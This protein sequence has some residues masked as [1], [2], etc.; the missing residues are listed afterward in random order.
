MKQGCTLPGMSEI[1]PFTLAIAEEQIADL[2]RRL[3]NTRWP[4]R[5]T[6][7]DW[8]QGAPLAEVQALCEHW[9]RNYD[10]RATESRLNS[11]GQYV[12][13]IDG[14]DIHFL[15]IRSGHDGALPLLLTHGWPGSIVEFLGVVDPLTNPTAHG[16]S[17]SDAF[18]LIIPSL[19]GYGFSGKPAA[20]GWGVERIATAWAELM[21]RLGYTRWVAQGGDW[22]AYVTN[23]LGAQAPEGLLGIHLNM[24]VTRRLTEIPSDPT[25][26]EQRALDARAHYARREAGYSTQQG[27]CPQ[28]IGYGLVD[29]PVALASWIYEK[30]HGWTDN[31]GH[32]EDAIARDSILDNIMVYWLSASGASAARLYWES[33]SAAGAPRD[34][35]LPAGV[36][37]FPFEIIQAPRK[38]T[39]Q[40]LHNIVYW[41][42][43]EQGGHFAAWEEPEIFT[44]EV[45]ACF[46]LMR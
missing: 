18:H 14:L 45:R 12:T 4:D 7:A 32:A 15:H 40:V 43:A 44:R 21:R 2:H 6:V 3:D 38:W 25:P 8:S 30:M 37:A 22:G 35:T 17:A 41:N 19:P 36:T 10:W 34:V 11:L 29:S 46:A 1:R 33:L 27:T 9:C 31:N 28:T 13:S 23:A 39:E 24:P 42:E 26:E 5:E 20:A 16:G